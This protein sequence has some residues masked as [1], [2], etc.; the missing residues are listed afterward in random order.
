[1]QPDQSPPRASGNPVLETIAVLLVVVAGL[2]LGAGILVPLVL[3]ILLAFALAPVVNLLERLHIPD[4]L[5]VLLAVL[6][7]AAMIGAFAY[8]ASTQVVGLAANLPGYQ[9]TVSEKL[10]GLQQS[11]GWGGEFI[12]RALDAA[13][14]LG[15]QFS[16]TG[17]G[18]QDSGMTRPVPVI[19]AN[20]TSDSLGL[21]STILG[22]ALG[23]LATVAIVTIF[24]IFLLLGRDDLRD[25]FIRLVSRGNFSTTTLV[26]NDAAARVGRYLLVQFGVNF[27]YGI[28]FG[29]G[30]MLIGVPNAILWGLMATLFRYIPF[31]GTIIVASIPFALAFAVDPGWNMLILS[32]ALFAGLE[33]ITTNAIEPRLYGTSTGLSPLAVLLAAMFWATIWGPIGLILSTPMTVC[34]VVLGRYVPQLAF[35]ETLLGSEPVLTPQERLYQRLLAGD[36]E[37]AIDIAEEAIEER[38]ARAFH[39]N[40]LL[41]ALRQA[42]QDLKNSPE[43]AMLRRRMANSLHELIEDITETPADAPRQVLLIGGKTE[44]DE[45]AAVIVGQIL[46]EDG[47]AADVLPPMAVRQ[48][49]I[50]QLDLEDYKIICLC[51]LGEEIRANV[52]YAARRLRRLKPDLSIIV[53]HLAEDG[54]VETAETLRADAIAA[55]LEQARTII[56]S[57]LKSPDAPIE[58]VAPLPIERAAHGNPELTK[59][60]AEIAEMLDMPLATIHLLSDERLQEEEGAYALTLEATADPKSI[61]IHTSDDK[62]PLS[63]NS[64]LI[65]NGVELY[66]AVPLVLPDERIIGTLAV[67][68]YEEKPFTETEIAALERQAAMLISRFGTRETRKPPARRR[69]TRTR[70]ATPG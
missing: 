36:T 20:D 22:S 50:G 35:L 60:L 62:N 7:A 27:T 18:L 41:P 33:L 38:G 16:G 48:E 65:E 47:I 25:R 12:Q 23:P 26:I 46:A 61:I 59:A 17:G 32:V 43:T 51:Y 63:S 29:T 8:V 10:Q 30:L 24:L 3:A 68:A 58:D 42:N 6:M 5:A 13:A 28:I 21:I 64:Y 9:S 2:Y 34:L 52:R 66:A 31:V 39:E 11:F 15:S 45:G 56:A 67:L 69:P 19:I 14:A 37:E 57:L 40:V 44:L 49:S 55:S 54:A 53:C 1:M 4:V 70:S